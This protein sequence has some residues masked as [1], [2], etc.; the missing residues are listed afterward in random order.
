MHLNKENVW[1]DE[2]S[3]YN[4]RSFR[5]DDLSINITPEVSCYKVGRRVSFILCWP[6]D[7]E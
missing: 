6:D 2:I 3:H 1:N 7:V 5:V 4:F